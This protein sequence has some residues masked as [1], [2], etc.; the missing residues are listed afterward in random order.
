MSESTVIR[1]DPKAYE[2]VGVQVSGEGPHIGG[3]LRTG[4]FPDDISYSA[5]SVL[6]L[7]ENNMA[8]VPH[9]LLCH[10]APCDFLLFQTLQIQLQ[11]RSFK[12]VMEI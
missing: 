5:S 2:E 7:T 8:V 3:A 9:P 12:A 1:R 6:F 11:G 4:T 10:L